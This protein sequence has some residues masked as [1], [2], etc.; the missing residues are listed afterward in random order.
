MRFWASLLVILLVACLAFSVPQA[1]AVGP[2]EASGAVASAERS[3]R[4]AFRA[5]SDA[6]TAGANVS[7]LID[8]LNEAGGGLTSSENALV[9]GNYSGAVDQAGMCK[10][11]ADGVS[12]DAAV[13]KS[14]SAAQAAGWWLT[15]SLSAAG[16]ALFAAALFLVWRRFKRAYERKLSQSRPEVVA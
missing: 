11:S 1:R 12:Y 4:D 15:V 13:L 2:E 6:E 14:D 8:R 5:V 3:L 16:A 10:A 7:A 9:V